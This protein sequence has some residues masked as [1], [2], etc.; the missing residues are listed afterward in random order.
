MANVKK[1]P[2]QSPDLNL[3]IAESKLTVVTDLQEL[4]PSIPHNMFT[5]RGVA[6]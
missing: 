5:R 2:K 6:V 3:F 1:F 4:P